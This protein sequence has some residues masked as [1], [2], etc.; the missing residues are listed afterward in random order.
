DLCPLAC[1]GHRPRL[2]RLGP[3]R[4]IRFW[5]Q[6]RITRFPGGQRLEQC[7]A[8][9]I[10]DDMA[11]LPALAGPDVDRPAVRI[12]IRGAQ[13]GEF[14]TACSGRKR[15][16]RQAPEIGITGIEKPLGLRN[17]QIARAGAVGFLEGLD[18]APSVIRWNLAL[19]PGTIERSLNDGQGSV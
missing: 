18:P 7:R 11:P 5:Q 14:A 12:E 6:Q 1:I 10:E 4:A 8:L 9:V 17:G 16:L 3:S 2:V 19:P 13:R 15:S